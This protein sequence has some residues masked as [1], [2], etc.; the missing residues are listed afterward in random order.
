MLQQHGVGA[1]ALINTYYFLSLAAEGQVEL[2]GGEACRT[3]GNPYELALGERVLGMANAEW[4]NT[5]PLTAPFVQGHSGCPSQA[6]PD[7]VGWTGGNMPWG[8]GRENPPV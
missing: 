4:A 3:S 5:A 6:L 2:H 1:E 7:A 8:T